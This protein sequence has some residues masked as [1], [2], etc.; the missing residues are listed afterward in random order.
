MDL[1]EAIKAHADWKMKL[2]TAIS[3]HTTLDADTIA[4]DN[5]C[6]LGKWLHGE[7]RARF[8]TLPAHH[9]C[10]RQH[11]LFHKEAGKVATSINQHKYS[12]AEQ[13]L[14]SGSPY[15]LASNA[16]VI[17]IGALKREAHL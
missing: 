2:R 17:A 6:M 5:C 15:A 4:K 7:S 10:M 3:A 14:V 1:N 9:E 13:M 12:E 16:V 11:A 8:G